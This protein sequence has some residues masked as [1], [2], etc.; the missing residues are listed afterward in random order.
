MSDLAVAPPRPAENNPGVAALTRLTDRIATLV[1]PPAAAE[2]TPP[3]AG[4][5]RGR[6]PSEAAVAASGAARRAS[7]L[8]HCACD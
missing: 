7:A 8:D 6:C 2:L 1:P 4:G 3:S 5:C